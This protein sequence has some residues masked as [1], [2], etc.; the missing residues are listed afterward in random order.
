MAYSFS[1]ELVKVDKDQGELVAVPVAPGAFVADDGLEFIHW[2]ERQVGHSGHRFAR[3]NE[4][5]HAHGFR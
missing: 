2:K 5:E 3:S 4:A 1:I